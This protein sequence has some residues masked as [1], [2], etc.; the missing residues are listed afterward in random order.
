MKVE[1]KNKITA[2]IEATDFFDTLPAEIGGYTLKKIFAE[3]PRKL[4]FCMYR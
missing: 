4:I 2:E 1:H 3:M